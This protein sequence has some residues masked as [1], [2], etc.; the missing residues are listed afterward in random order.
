MIQ[1]DELLILDGKETRMPFCPPLPHGHPRVVETKTDDPERIEFNEWISSRACLC[2]YRG[3]WEIK[4]DRL[5]L[6]NLQGIY[7]LVGDA[8]LPADWF[9]GFLRIPRRDL[10]F[11]FHKEF[12]EVWEKERSMEINNGMVVKSWV[13]DMKGREWD[14]FALGLRKHPG[15]GNSVV[16]PD[17]IEYSCSEDNL[18]CGFCGRYGVHPECRE[19]VNKIWADKR[20]L[21]RQFTIEGRFGPVSSE[22][23]M[24]L[25]D[26]V[27]RLRKHLGHEPEFDVTQVMEN[28]NWWLIPHGWIGMLG[29][30][31]DKHTG[32]IAALG[33][34]WGEL[35]NAIKAYEAGHIELDPPCEESL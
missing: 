24:T 26:A 29:F 18:F 34:G 4:E 6:V 7:K 9:T 22:P 21:L 25:E 23:E 32:R 17:F 35:L 31:V 33:S 30:I 28:R 5:Y 8:P 12:G 13:I 11:F 3:T 10:V 1:M 2:Q 19:Q 27:F 15:S 16:V 14:E 20:D